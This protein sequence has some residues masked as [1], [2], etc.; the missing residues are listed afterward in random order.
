MKPTRLVDLATAVVQNKNGQVLLLERNEKIFYKHWQFPEGKI[1]KTENPKHA[2]VRELTEEL[3]G[4]DT[5][6]VSKLG[7]F[8]ISFRHP[9]GSRPQLIKL[10]RIT[11]LVKISGE[12]NLSEEHSGWGWFTASDALNLKL[13]PGVKEIIQII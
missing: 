6:V 8:S 1:K 10:V 11:Y 5:T 3:G 2:L 9:L 13:A 4:A 12:I 7:E